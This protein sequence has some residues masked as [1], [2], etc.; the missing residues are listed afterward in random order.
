MLAESA[1][2]EANLVLAQE[3]NKFPDTPNPKWA[4]Y[5]KDPLSPS[6]EVIEVPRTNEIATKAIS[7]GGFG[8][9]SRM[10][11]GDPIK[12]DVKRLNERPVTDVDFR[13]MVLL[14]CT[15]NVGSYGR[16]VTRA[17]EYCRY[18][19]VPPGHLGAYSFVA[20]DWSYMR[21]RWQGYTG[22]LLKHAAVRQYV[23]N[24]TNAAMDAKKTIAEGGKKYCSNV[25]SA[26]SGFTVSDSNSKYD[27]ARGRN[28]PEKVVGYLGEQLDTYH[29]DMKDATVDGY[30]G[31]NAPKSQFCLPY[32]VTMANISTGNLDAVKRM[33]DKL[34]LDPNDLDKYK[35]RQDKFA[36]IMQKAKDIA[37][38]I[39]NEDP[40]A[41]DSKIS[42]DVEQFLEQEAKHW[43][44]DVGGQGIASPIYVAADGGDP[45]CQKVEHSMLQ[46]HVP[47]LPTGS[48]NANPPIELPKFSVPPGDAQINSS[49]P[50]RNGSAY[51][52]FNPAEIGADQG[53]LGT[54][55]K[56]FTTNRSQ[57]DPNSQYSLQ[58]LK[59]I[60]SAMNGS[61]G[62]NAFGQDKST[63]ETFKGDWENGTTDFQSVMAGSGGDGTFDA[64]PSKNQGQ[65]PGQ[66][67]FMHLSSIKEHT[68]SSPGGQDFPISK[69]KSSL[70]ISDRFN[71]ARAC[72][73]F[74]DP[75]SFAA[76]SV[77]QM[78]SGNKGN[79]AGG[80][81][82]F[83]LAGVY[84]IENGGAAGKPLVL[85]EKY[86]GMGVIASNGPIE[87]K[88]GI[89]K[90]SD[91][92]CGNL[93]LI[94]EKHITLGGSQIDA[95]VISKDTLKTDGSSKPTI[96][97]NLIVKDT[98][99][100]Q[101]GTTLT[102]PNPNKVDVT[103][104]FDA[105]NNKLPA[106][107]VEYDDRLADYSDKY[108]IMVICPYRVAQNCK[109]QT[110][111]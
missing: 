56:K 98:Q 85:P 99:D 67:K 90:K 62:S 106:F 54:L 47:S 30:S 111:W 11:G 37:S 92:D 26:V 61:A 89:A 97:G 71:R 13:G 1:I 49:G 81:G 42:N 51:F 17:F 88:Q 102:Q 45:R 31:P 4:A 20:L 91:Q 58:E 48:P 19:I 14:E 33:A 68:P 70:F 36:S 60:N 77:T 55:M 23:V 76:Y 84:F 38:T 35:F 107:T 28:E 12:V 105:N 9:S 72:Y 43:K 59:T 108:Q 10:L 53:S 8:I 74:P 7:D 25:V 39:T 21:D 6:E 79:N 75:G 83:K 5:F 15:V 29:K 110:F 40:A 100:G 86:A 109:R 63:F 94:S 80:K 18:K 95:S 44:T 87:L 34:Q 16:V 32:L 103:K 82:P 52:F 50:K 69:L 101:Q 78:T 96:K 2:N 46:F 104:Y 65:L 24:R 73:Y 22:L 41:I 57:T 93:I 64:D 3:I 66:A 27:G